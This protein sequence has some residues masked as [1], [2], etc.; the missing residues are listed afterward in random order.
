MPTPSI[1][2]VTDYAA[3]YAA[4]FTWLK[5]NS[6]A[7]MGE[8]VFSNQVGDRQPLPYATILVIADNIKTGFDDIRP[9]FVGGGTPKQSYRTVGMREMTLQVTM[10]TE[11][12]E[13]VTDIEAN[14]RLNSALITLD[15]PALNQQFNDANLTILGHTPIIKLDEQ[16]GERWER[17]SSSDLRMMYTAESIDDGSFGEWVETVEVPTVDNGNL[18][19]NI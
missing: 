1:T 11:P 3:M 7:D 13:S 12:A 19:A 18:T 5:E 8:V 15:H 14:E 10:Y 6:L 16:L 17:R 2:I 4:L 9:E